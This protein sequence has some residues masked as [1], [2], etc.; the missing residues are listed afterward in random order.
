MVH[1]ASFA[2]LFLKML[3][4]RSVEGI[5]LKT[6]E[7]Y[8]LVFVTRYLDLFHIPTF[9]FL[10][11]YNTCMKIIYIAASATIVYYIRRK[12]PWKASYKKQEDSFMHLQFAIAPC[13]AL[14][15]LIHSEFTIVELFWTFSIYLEAVAIMPQLILMQRFGNVEN[16]TANYVACLGAYRALYILNWI[17][18]L[19]YEDH[20]HSSKATW[21]VWISG[22]VQTA[23]YCD[24]FYYYALSKWYNKTMLPQ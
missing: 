3:S 19:Y 23:L 8:L 21:I 17:Y 15:L 5:S 4:S 7:L 2:V 16:L 9:T 12:N 24:F 13:A 11:V 18:R 22:V 14:A 20:Y 1:L 6:Q 10:H